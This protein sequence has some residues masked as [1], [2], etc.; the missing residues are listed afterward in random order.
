MAAS[1]E[2]DISAESQHQIKKCNQIKSS[3]VLQTGSERDNAGRLIDVVDG[4]TKSG[5]PVQI[6]GC[7]EKRKKKE[8]KKSLSFT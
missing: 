6:W 2:W 1:R 8:K 5:E 4:I 3:P 7:V